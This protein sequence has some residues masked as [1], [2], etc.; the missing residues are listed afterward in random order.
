MKSESKVE[1]GVMW[2]VVA[3]FGWFFLQGF[4]WFDWYLMLVMVLALVSGIIY[5]IKAIVGLYE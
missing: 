1:L 4:K 3:F 5:L 2:I